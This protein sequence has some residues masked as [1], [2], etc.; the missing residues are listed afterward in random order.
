MLK[1]DRLLRALR[2]QPVDRTPVWLMRQA[3]RYLPE[4]RATR[5]RAGSFLGMAKNP[6]IACEVTLQPL[7]RFPLDAA[8]LFSDILTIPDAMGLELYFV[9]GEG[10]KFRHPVRDADA[11]HRLGVPDMETELRYVMDAVRLIRR[12]LDGAVPL[13]GF[14]GS[15]WTLA[16]YMI[17]G[18]GSKEYARIKAM[19]FNAPQLLHHL[20]ST[21]TDAVIAYLSAQR[22]A[23]AQ[24]LQVFDTWGGVLSP[25]MYREFSLPYLTRI[26]QELERGSGEERTPL[27]LFGKGNGAYVSE[28][29]A[30]GAEAVGVDWTIS[31][32]DAAERAGGRV[33]LQGNLDP[34]TL[35]GSPEAIRSEV[36]KTLD[37]YAYGNGGSR[38]GHVFNLGHGMSP[39]MNPDHVGVLVEAVQTLSKR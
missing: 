35:Y 33:A 11:I 28:L 37:S 36:G 7:E 10:P 27:V 6:D 34:A 15:P 5:A 8:I 21:V 17:E 12:E 4:Y 30:S 39:D 14:S 22:A 9:E 38:E 2:R 19:A 13:I 1:N 3:G 24:A 23:G 26:A 29:A 18:G 20:P 16:C 31:L 32:A 25:A